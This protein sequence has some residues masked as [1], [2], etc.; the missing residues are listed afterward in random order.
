MMVNTQEHLVSTL[1]LDC[2]GENWDY[3]LGLYLSCCMGC[4]DYRLGLKENMMEMLE[5]TMVMWDC[6]LEMT[7][8]MD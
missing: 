2:T 7:G 8:C 1:H 6:N 4:W 5:S 3:N